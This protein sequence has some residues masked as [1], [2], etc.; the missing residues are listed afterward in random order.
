MSKGDEKVQRYK[1]E[2]K[3]K[4]HGWHLLRHGS[5]HDI[6]TDGKSKEKIPRHPEINEKLAR[7]LIRKHKLN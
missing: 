1:L 6:W 5:N 4:E 3:F 7:G 2:K